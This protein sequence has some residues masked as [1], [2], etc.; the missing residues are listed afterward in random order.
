MIPFIF[1]NNVKTT[2]GAA[3]TSSATTM[4]VASSAGFPSISAGQYLPVVLRDAATNLVVEVVYATAITGAT[5]TIVRGQDGTTAQTWGIG[6]I[7][8]ITATANTLES[9]ATEITGVISAAGLTPSN[10]N[11]GQL[12]AAIQS[13]TFA[14]AIAQDVT[15]SRTF[16][17]VYTN[18]TGR[19]ISVS[20]VTNNNT[21]GWGLTGYVNGAP[22]QAAY[23]AS[24]AAAA[25][26]IS[27]PVIPPGATYEIAQTTGTPTL[28]K[29]V[30][31]R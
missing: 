16:G 2:L 4:T 11:L 9:L 23:I 27:L 1:A 22:Y 14:G 21:A 20:A 31:V 25:I 13:L 28:S 29:W 19:P 8:Q 3:L 26:G 18:S 15:A 24:G 10:T 12:L 30:E 5:L 7:V 17:T 6:D